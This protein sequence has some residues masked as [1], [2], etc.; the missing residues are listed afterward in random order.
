MI[1]EDV[2]FEPMRQEI[3]RTLK[4]GAMTRVS[5]GD[6]V[7]ASRSGKH[8]NRAGLALVFDE[9]RTGERSG[10]NRDGNRIRLARNRVDANEEWAKDA[11]MRGRIA[12]VLLNGEPQGW[13]GL[14]QEVRA[15]YPEDTFE[16]RRFERV[17]IAMLF[18]E[19]VA[20]V[21]VEGY[22]RLGPGR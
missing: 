4:L 15:T 22:C 11:V 21:D 5:V 17:W 8:F 16:V 7:L 18:R 1:T 13:A 2:Y 9:L 3:R 14:S 19:W 6:R 20:F 10:C 12:D